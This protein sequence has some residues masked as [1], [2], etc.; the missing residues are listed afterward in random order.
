MIL[1]YDVM[2]KLT[3]FPFSSKLRLLYKAFV[4]QI[5]AERAANGNVPETNLGL[6][7]YDF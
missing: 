1:K 6:S 7:V 3:T 5:V 4:A 2:P